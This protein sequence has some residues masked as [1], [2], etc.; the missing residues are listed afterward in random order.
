MKLV[1]PFILRCSNFIH[2]L[3][4]INRIDSSEDQKFLSCI[5][6]VERLQIM[7]RT[8]NYC[9]VMRLSKRQRRQNAWKRIRI[10][11]RKSSEISKYRMWNSVYCVRCSDAISMGDWCK[12]IYIVLSFFTHAFCLAL[13]AFFHSFLSIL[14]S[15][16][17]FVSFSRSHIVSTRFWLDAIATLTCACNFFFRSIACG[18]EFSLLSITLRSLTLARATFLKRSISKWVCFCCSQ[19]QTGK[20][21][22]STLTQLFPFSMKLYWNCEWVW[23]DVRFVEMWHER[24]YFFKRKVLEFRLK[25]ISLQRNERTFFYVCPTSVHWNRRDSR[26][27][28]SILTHS[29]ILPFR[30][31]AKNFTYARAPNT[32]SWCLLCC[33]CCCCCRRNRHL[34]A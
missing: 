14:F 32:M 20:H 12:P 27:R 17:L 34:Y 6:I 10:I 5:L 1:Q 25:K 24:K 13:I 3:K 9:D 11:Y 19:A 28:N 33:C 16:I 8:V 2:S 4:S 7:L 21:T 31:I 23:I 22:N 18:S 30:C 26:H 15:L 29:I